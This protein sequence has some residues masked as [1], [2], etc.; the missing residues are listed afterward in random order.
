MLGMQKLSKLIGASDALPFA[1]Q[2]DVLYTAPSGRCYQAFVI[3]VDPTDCMAYVSMYIPEL[4]DFM[5]GWRPFES[6]ELN[7][8]QMSL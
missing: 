7:E 4:D 8:F 6:L 3:S 5:P 1:P 2:D